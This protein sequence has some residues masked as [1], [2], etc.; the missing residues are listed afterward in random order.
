M[1]TKALWFFPLFAL[2]I[3]LAFVLTQ[4]PALGAPQATPTPP[5][6]YSLLIG[7]PFEDIHGITDAGV[8][9]LVPG[10]AGSGLDPARATLWSQDVLTD[11]AEAYDYF[12]DVMVSGDFNG[13]GY[14]D[15]AVGLPLEDWESW[16]GLD[17]VADAGAVNVIY[18]GPN[19]LTAEGHQFWTQNET[20]VSAVE[21]GD[22]FGY[23]LA[24]GDFNGDGYDDLAIGTPYEDLEWEGSPI[25]DT[26][27]V[28]IL[29]GSQN[30]LTP[31]HDLLKG[32]LTQED[33]YTC[34]NGENDRFGAALASGDFDADGY[35]DLA[36][37]VPLESEDVGVTEAGLILEFHG[38]GAV[39]L[40]DVN[41]WQQ[42]SAEVGDHFG[43]VLVTGDFN[44]DGADD[45]AAGTP[46]EDTF[47][48][49][50]AGAVFILYG[51]MTR[52]LTNVGAQEWWQDVIEGMDGNPIDP[53]EAG[54]HF[55]NALAVGDFDGDGYDDLA[56]GIPTEDSGSVGSAD[57][58]AVQVLMSNSDGLT[59]EDG[60][61]LYGTQQDGWLGSALA[62]GDFDLDGYDDLAVGEP[63]WDATYVDAGR[64]WLLYGEGV[65]PLTF[66]RQ[67]TLDSNDLPANA[68]E[69]GDYL[70]S[71][72]AVLPPTYRLY[73]PLVLR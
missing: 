59:V 65:R 44:G 55:G 58:G 50:D 68:E 53:S 8:F 35:D 26:G 5:P 66:S 30:G 12:A 67:V 17:T 42:G 16:D 33:F 36:V 43:A 1:R 64:V 18:N 2:P 7:T 56:V 51:E 60:F 39:G 27:V 71:S 73:L 19:G 20:G 38:D 24:A 21:E 4:S 31:A 22:E 32:I 52:G 10:I 63:G 28:I 49:V 3:L 48:T 9:N 70:G 25:T 54:D 40:D 15:V 69:A 46:D 13:D 6:A 61:I 11:G 41:V 29:Y 23:A 57:R 62:A 14:P 34:N 37:G 72:L 45:L 47:S